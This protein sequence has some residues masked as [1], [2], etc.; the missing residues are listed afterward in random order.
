[1]LKASRLKEACHLASPWL[2]RIEDSREERGSGSKTWKKLSQGICALDAKL[3]GLN[4]DKKRGNKL[5]GC[6]NTASEIAKERLRG[7]KIALVPL[8]L[9]AT[10]WL[11]FWAAAQRTCHQTKQNSKTPPPSELEE[12]GAGGVISEQASQLDIGLTFQNGEWTPTQQ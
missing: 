6:I 8:L 5:T 10:L 7:A 9:M 2:K 3:H 12:T 4:R 1:M 11:L